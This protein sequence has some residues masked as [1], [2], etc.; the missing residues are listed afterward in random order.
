MAKLPVRVHKDV[1]EH[2]ESYTLP[3]EADIL[4]LHSSYP[5]NPSHRLV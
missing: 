2:D 5:G 4:V 3:M 1:D